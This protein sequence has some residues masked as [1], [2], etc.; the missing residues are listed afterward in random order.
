MMQI[1]NKEIVLSDGSTTGRGTIIVLH[2]TPTRRIVKSLGLGV[3][4]L[5]LTA[6]TALIPIAHFLLVPLMLIV[7]VVCSVRAFTTK[8]LLLSGS[9]TCPACEGAFRILRRKYRLPFNDVCESC[10][11]EITISTPL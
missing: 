7:T 11:R 3:A 1:Q 10:H 4:L 6:T 2:L 8:D 9:G 5:L